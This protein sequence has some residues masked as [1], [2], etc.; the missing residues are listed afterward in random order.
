MFTLPVKLFTLFGFIFLSLSLIASGK[1]MLKPSQQQQQSTSTST[2]LNNVQP[3]FGIGPWVKHD[4]ATT[5]APSTTTV[6]IKKKVNNY[7]QK[8]LPFPEAFSSRSS[9]KP[10]ISARSSNPLNNNVRPSSTNSPSGSSLK[11]S[12]S[13]SSS[14]PIEYGFTDSDYPYI[15][16]KSSKV[17][18]SSPEYRSDY[19]DESLN[20]PT[21]TPK[22]TS[23]STSSY[24]GKGR[25][26]LKCR[27]S[28]GRQ[29][30]D[31]Q[32]KQ[33]LAEKRSTMTSLA[34]KASQLSYLNQ[35]IYRSS[36]N[37]DNEGNG[38]SSEPKMS[39]KLGREEEGGKGRDEDDYRAK[40][41]EKWSQG[42]RE[43]NSDEFPSSSTEKSKP[44]GARSGRSSDYPSSPSSPSSPSPQG[45]SSDDDHESTGDQ[46]GVSYFADK[47][48][49]DEDKYYSAPDYNYREESPKKK[50][51]TTSYGSSPP[52]PSKSKS[53][54]SSSSSS[55][56]SS[57][58]SSNP[59]SES[60]DDY[61]DGPSEAPEGFTTSDS[62]E[63]SYQS[64]D[65][66][67]S[68]SSYDKSDKNDKKQSSEPSYNYRGS[69]E[70][71]TSKSSKSSNPSNDG[72]PV[73]YYKPSQGYDDY[74]AEGRGQ[75]KKKRKS[76]EYKAEYK[77][78][79]SYDENDDDSG[80]MDYGYNAKSGKDEGQ[81]YDDKPRKNRSNEEEEFDAAFKE[82]LSGRG[83][84]YHQQESRNVGKFAN[85]QKHVKPNDSA[86]LTPSSSS[87]SSSLSLP[88]SPSMSLYTS[89]PSSQSTSPS[90]SFTPSFTSHKVNSR[91]YLKPKNGEKAVVKASMMVD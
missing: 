29:L 39:S 59:A 41:E 3:F 55:A 50:S 36:N 1:V 31:E 82:P 90:T 4:V 30:S 43:W 91:N 88:S 16:V 34:G 25:K 46:L 44:F 67:Y 85:R 24:Q 17:D 52:S 60:Y 38:E 69:D 12:A 6:S 48:N 15:V 63:P 70:Y 37:Q 68:K 73:Q 75:E 83:F 18:S 81:S 26:V 7:N 8:A 42:V 57:S 66:G 27:T 32:C 78:D 9:Q 56:S 71:L 22:P 86:K 62:D 19:Y 80:S 23:S 53:G 89:S 87:S 28:D 74:A 72:E 10:T 2:Q 54:R 35:P 65:S 11:P 58:S 79:E 14:S 61:S 49:T 64:D 76:T 84:N 51:A 47:G 77:P 20:E 45:S 13:S 33:Q 21:S 40:E 5:A